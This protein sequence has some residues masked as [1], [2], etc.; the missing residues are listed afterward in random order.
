MPVIVTVEIQK[1]CKP[2]RSLHLQNFDI[3]ARESGIVH[4]AVVSSQ[5][6]GAVRSHS[7]ISTYD[8][9]VSSAARAET[10]SRSA[11]SLWLPYRISTRLIAE[12]RS[13]RGMPGINSAN[14]FSGERSAPTVRSE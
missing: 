5:C 6:E 11:T 14:G 8:L 9:E 3:A 1:V 4:R 13:E 12:M 2:G 10:D 7:R